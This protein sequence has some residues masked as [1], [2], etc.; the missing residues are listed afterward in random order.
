MIFPFYCLILLS[1]FLSL[2]VNIFTVSIILSFFSSIYLSIHLTINVF[3][4]ALVSGC[5]FSMHPCCRSISVWTASLVPKLPGL[6]RDSWCLFSHCYHSHSVPEYA[7]SRASP[8]AGRVWSL[9]FLRRRTAC[10]KPPLDKFSSLTPMLAKPPA[11]A[12]Y[13]ILAPYDTRFKMQACIL[14]VKLN[15]EASEAFSYFPS[16]AI[17]L[18]F[19]SDP[20]L[21]G[22]LN[23][24]PS[25]SWDWS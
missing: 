13:L 10:I 19:Y 14:N 12:W 1:L 5:Y 24:F 25:V 3:E 23:P 22:L 8:S 2:A 17:P 4:S 15:L 21:L 9:C 20:T 7:M 16:K 18:F 6:W 11:A